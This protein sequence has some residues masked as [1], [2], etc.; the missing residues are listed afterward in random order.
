MSVLLVRSCA[1]IASTLIRVRDI[2]TNY[3][4]SRAALSLFSFGR[5]NIHSWFR[6]R[7]SSIVWKTNTGSLSTIRN[8]YR[9]EGTEKERGRKKRSKLSHSLHKSTEISYSFVGLLFF[10]GNVDRSAA[11][12]TY[13]RSRECIEPVK[14]WCISGSINYWISTSAAN[15]SGE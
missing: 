4:E 14:C 12:R 11:G 2:S 3:I 7:F 8:I 5:T 15:G 9:P 13:T 1:E 6:G 10:R